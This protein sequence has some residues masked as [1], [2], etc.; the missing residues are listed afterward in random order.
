MALRVYEQMKSQREA[1]YT[2]TPPCK[3]R[4]ECIRSV[5]RTGRGFKANQVEVVR[6]VAVICSVRSVREVVTLAQIQGQ[7]VTRA[8]MWMVTHRLHA[9]LA[10][11]RHHLLGVA[12][13]DVGVRKRERGQ[14]KPTGINHAIILS[15]HAL[16]GVFR[17]YA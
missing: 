5:H 16:Y 15:K 10:A 4:H 12:P 17:I 6:D 3:I 11:L 13:G 9:E 2:R 1:T 14:R 8:V 7:R